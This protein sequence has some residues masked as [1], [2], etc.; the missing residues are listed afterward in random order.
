MATKDIVDS[1]ADKQTGTRTLVNTY[2]SK[3]TA[4]ISFPF[5]FFPFALIPLMINEGILESYLWPLTFLLI[6]SC[7]VFYLMTRESDSKT[8]ENVHAWSIMYIE[9][10]LFAMGFSLMIIFRGLVY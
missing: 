10:M 4:L 5:M 9:Y 8:L 2:G 3:K 7:L 6:L 1:K